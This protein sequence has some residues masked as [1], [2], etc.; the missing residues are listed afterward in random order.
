MTQTQLQ[1][2]S[3]RRSNHKPSQAY[4][5]SLLSEKKDGQAMLTNVGDLLLAAQQLQAEGFI[6]AISLH[7]SA[8]TGL[9]FFTVT[10]A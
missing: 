5:L 8:I 3:I 9:G 1:A 4:V 2:E 10:A 7:R 6:S